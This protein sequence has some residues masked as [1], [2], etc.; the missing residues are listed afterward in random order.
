MKYKAGDKVYLR[1]DLKN[2]IVY[3]D[4]DWTN[5]MLRGTWGTIKMVYDY[6]Y[7][8]VGDFTYSYNDIMIDHEKTAQ[9]SNDTT[10]EKPD[11]VVCMT[12]KEAIGD[13]VNHPKHYTQG[14]IETIDKIK[15]LTREFSGIEAVCIGNFIKYIDR[16][17]LKGGMQDL[18]K[19]DWY[20]NRFLDEFY[21]EFHDR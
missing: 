16:C 4:L 5:G 15:Y 6:D 8:I 1:D 3:D 11:N 19:A 9:L 18:E 13:M 14:E 10:D 20:L 17:N 2:N 7:D 12:E 21:D